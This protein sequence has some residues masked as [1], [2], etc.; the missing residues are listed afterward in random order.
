MKGNKE[1][2]KPTLHINQREYH[3][4]IRLKGAVGFCLLN[5]KDIKAMGIVA[6]LIDQAIKAEAM[7]CFY[8][9]KLYRNMATAIEGK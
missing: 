3:T 6:S 8:S 7:N 2:Q 4:V 1:M 9:S 5:N